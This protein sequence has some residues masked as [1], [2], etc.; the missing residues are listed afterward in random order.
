MMDEISR[1]GKHH[2]ASDEAVISGLIDF[3]LATRSINDAKMVT[4]ARQFDELLMFDEL[5][6]GDLNAVEESLS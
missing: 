4:L 5:T 3:D 6:T 2:V 1:V